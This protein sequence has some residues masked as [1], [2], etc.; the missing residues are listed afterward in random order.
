MILTSS[1]RIIATFGVIILVTLEQMKKKWF[2]DI[3]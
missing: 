2:L 3:V 1:P